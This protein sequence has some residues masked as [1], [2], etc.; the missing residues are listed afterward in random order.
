MAECDEA[1]KT[2]WS[3]GYVQSRYGEQEEQRD[4]QER[5][6]EGPGERKKQWLQQTHDE[7]R[8]QGPSVQGKRPQ[9]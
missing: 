7:K 8:L 5:K 6:E 9:G 3:G 1:K 2:T 4:L